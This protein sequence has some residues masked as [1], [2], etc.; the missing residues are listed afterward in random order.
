MGFSAGLMSG[1][2]QANTALVTAKAHTNA[3]SHMD[4]R[5]AVLE[6][7]IKTQNGDIE[8]KKAELKQI[9]E[10]REKAA[11]L[12]QDALNQANASIGAATAP[13]E[14]ENEFGVKGAKDKDTNTAVSDK[15]ADKEKEI[16]SKREHHN[17]AAVDYSEG[18]KISEEGATNVAISP[19][20]LEQMADDGALDS[21]YMHHLDTMAKIDAENK[22]AYGNI[23]DQVWSVDKNGSV[24]HYATLAQGTTSQ[25]AQ[26]QKDAMDLRGREAFGDAFAGAHVRVEGPS[27]PVTP[28]QN[29]GL[30]LD[31]SM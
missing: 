21:T 3:I 27:K 20:F 6:S 9:G 24:R 23:T 10:Q 14:N 28:P 13:E 5:A 26:A 16:E 30:L 8:G 12:Q 4:S 15:A 19:E 31:L 25:E 1:L 2:M 17:V 11:A 22:A 7:E 18:M 29:A